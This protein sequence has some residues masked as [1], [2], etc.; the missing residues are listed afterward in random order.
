MKRITWI[1]LVL[2]MSLAPQLSAAEPVRIIMASKI[3]DSDKSKEW[4]TFSSNEHKEIY[5][6]PVPSLKDT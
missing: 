5:A 2:L 4:L 1:V 3:L 6:W